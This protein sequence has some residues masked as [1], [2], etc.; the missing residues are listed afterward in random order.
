MKLI[1]DVPISTSCEMTLRSLNAA[2]TDAY[3]LEALFLYRRVHRL[4]REYGLIS[5]H[6]ACRW[7]HYS[8]P[9]GQ[10][11]IH[12]QKLSVP[13]GRTALSEGFLGAFAPRDV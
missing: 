8:A 11:F 6:V 9:N 1:Y 2:E 12:F 3:A 10:V 4:K 13:V 5:F 7:M